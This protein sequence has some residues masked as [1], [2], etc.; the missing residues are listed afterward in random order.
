[1]HAYRG[2]DTAP[3]YKRYTPCLTDENKKGCPKTD[4]LQVNAKPRFF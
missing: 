1:M 4:S 3:I 2:N